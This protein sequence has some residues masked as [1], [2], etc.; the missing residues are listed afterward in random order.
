MSFLPVSHGFLN[1]IDTV[2]ILFVGFSCRNLTY[3]TIVAL[4][5]WAYGGL[6]CATNPSQSIKDK[7]GAKASILQIFMNEAERRR[8]EDT[9]EQEAIYLA[10]HPNELDNI[11]RILRLMQRAGDPPDMNKDELID[12]IDYSCFFR[13]LYGSNARLIINTNAGQKMNHMFVRVIYDGDQFMDI[14]PQGTWDR[15]SM[16][17]IWG[18][19]YNTY[20]NRDVTAQWTQVVGGMQ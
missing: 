17:L 5:M 2:H 7:E 14:E 19:K 20:Y 6:G 12:C 15:Y 16:G 10:N 3:F 18:V 1:K 9:I 11:P 13:L 4:V 8:T